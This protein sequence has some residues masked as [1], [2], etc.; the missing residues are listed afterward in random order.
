MCGEEQTVVHLFDRADGTPLIHSQFIA[1]GSIILRLITLEYQRVSHTVGKLIA[2]RHPRLVV[3][4]YLKLC[5]VE[6][7]V[8]GIVLC[9]W[10]V[11]HVKHL[12]HQRQRGLLGRHPS[13]SAAV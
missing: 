9:S 12:L 7:K 8:S 11:C 10:G 6:P 13:L 5:I 1:E 4:L 2:T 3:F